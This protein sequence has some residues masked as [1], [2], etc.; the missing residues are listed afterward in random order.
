MFLT[1]QVA[2]QASLVDLLTSLLLQPL[3]A[4]QTPQVNLV[5]PPSDVFV[6][7]ILTGPRGKVIHTENVV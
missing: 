3:P 4:S 5:F 6:R 7:Y 2:V 1:I